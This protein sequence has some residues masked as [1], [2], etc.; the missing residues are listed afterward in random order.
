M[1]FESTA[2]D[3]VASIVGFIV[4]VLEEKYASK[5]TIPG[6][7]IFVGRV[8]GALGSGREGNAAR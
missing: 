6:I 3:E 4:R 2:G 1:R 7:S 5:G 8:D